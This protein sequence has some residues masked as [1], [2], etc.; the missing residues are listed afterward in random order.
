MTLVWE[1]SRAEGNLLLLALALADW[2]DDDGY[3]YPSFRQ[4][5]RKARVDRSTAIRGIKKLLTLGE[6]EQLPDGHHEIANVGRAKFLRHQRTNG[7]RL[8]MPQLASGAVPLPRS[9]GGGA[10]PLPSVRQVVA[11]QAD[12][13]VANSS[14]SISVSKSTSVKSSSADA[15]RLAD[16]PVQTVENRA[17]YKQLEV[18]VHDTMNGAETFEGLGDFS[19]AV[20]IRCAELQLLYDPSELARAIASVTMVRGFERRATRR[21][22]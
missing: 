18:V 9:A 2:C 4:L 21:A 14:V 11:K 3:C 8:L 20:K 5:A 13:V 7:Y 22:R 16:H 10:L 12:Q 6:I 15:P 19:E 17:T 1:H